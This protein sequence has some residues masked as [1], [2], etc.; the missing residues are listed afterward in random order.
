MHIHIYKER[1][2]N[3]L[4]KSTEEKKNLSEYSE[5]RRFL[6]SPF[7][8]RNLAF[9]RFFPL[10]RIT[11]SAGYRRQESNLRLHEETED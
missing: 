7:L 3:I 2:N 6:T 4:Q 5:K 8:F 11:K 10:F 9:A 1:Q